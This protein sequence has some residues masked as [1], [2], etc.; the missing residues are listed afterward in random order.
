[1]RV[2]VVC[3][4]FRAYRIFDIAMGDMKWFPRRD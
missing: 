4:L 3:V 2:E 1:M